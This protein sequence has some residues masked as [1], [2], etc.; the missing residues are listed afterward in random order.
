MRLEIGEIAIDGVE[1]GDST[2]IDSRRRVLIINRA[3]LVEL[4]AKDKRLTNISVELAHP[5][6]RVRLCR[7]HDILEPRCRTGD[8][9]G[10]FPFPGALGVRGTAGNG[11]LNALKGVC[12]TMTDQGGPYVYHPDMGHP[13]EDTPIGFVMDMSGKGAEV[14]PFSKLHHVVVNAH[15]APGIYH[16]ENYVIALRVAGLRA[17]AYLGRA[18]EDL[19]PEKITVF[20]LPTIPEICKGKEHLPKVGFVFQVGWNQWPP[21]DGEPIYYGDDLENFQPRLAHPNELLDGALTRQYFGVGASTYVFQNNPI[22]LEL[23]RR[24]GRDLNFMG[25]ILDLS[26]CFEPERERAVNAVA[27]LVKE[28]LGLDGVILNKFGGGAPM[29]DTSQR[30]VACEKHGVAAVAIMADVTYPDGSNGLLFNQAEC[31]AMINTGSL[32]I[33]PKGEPQD[34]VIGRPTDMEPSA[35]ADLVKAGFGHVFG[36]MDQLGDSDNCVVSRNPVTVK[37]VGKTGAER[38]V[39]MVLAKIKGEPFKTELPLADWIHPDPAPQID[40]LSKAKIG[41]VTAGGLI[42]KGNPDNL[43]AGFSKTF[44]AYSIRKLDRL[45]ADGYKTFH[46]GFRTNYTDADPQRV[47][48]LDV[49]RDIEREGLIGKLNDV[50]YS[51]AGVGTSPINSKK[52]GEGIARRLKADGVDAVIM[53]AT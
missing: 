22:I 37:K 45:C 18:A 30:V 38:A 44:G 33:P 47:V 49:L 14:T 9:K 5:G 4:I 50:L 52:I 43:S 46:V 3:E 35:M 1:F 28:I 10:Q 8:R 17:S 40:D 31:N 27:K 11:G 41:L 15:P 19:E 6:E 26:I 24:H 36:S 42:P 21:I 25:V 16:I 12:L 7:I 23:Y 53:T 20:E 51:Y 2:K 13:S 32:I 29:V 34:R 39:D 48:P